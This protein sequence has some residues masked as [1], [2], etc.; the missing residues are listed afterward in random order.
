[1]LPLCG[2]G[3]VY[4]FW[5]KKHFYF[6]ELLSTFKYINPGPVIGGWTRLP[7]CYRTA[8]YLPPRRLC[9]RS[10]SSG[11]DANAPSPSPDA[12]WPV[13]KTPK[14][15]LSSCLKRNPLP[16]FP[17][18]I[19][20]LFSILL[21]NGEKTFTFFFFLHHY[22]SLCRERQKKQYRP[23][24]QRREDNPNIIILL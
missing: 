22:R 23:V 11:F 6:C 17:N 2:W 15:L 19:Q 12:A 8:W 18:I 20:R 5:P 9:S 4:P 1:M 21:K 14:T 7:S 24:Y 3:Y 13:G 10:P 16:S